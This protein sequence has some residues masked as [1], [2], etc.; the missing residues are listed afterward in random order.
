M[1]KVL[2][3]QGAKRIMDVC[4]KVKEEEKV[5]I[6][7]DYLK[8]DIAETLAIAANERGAEVAVMIMKARDMDGAEPPSHVAAAMKNADVIFTPLSRSITHS[9]AVKEAIESGTRGI[10]LSAFVQDQLISGGVYGD[11]EKIEPFC[12]KVAKLLEE[13][14]IAH[15]IN[16]A[17]TDI[18]M[19]L[20]NRVGNHH[21]GLAHNKGDFTTVPNI[22]ASI[23]P[24]EGSAEGTIVADASI[25]YYDIGVLETPVKY[26]VEKG[27]IIEITGGR[28]AKDI[29]KIM[30]DVNNDAVYNI[31]QLA[32]GLNPECKMRGVMLDDEGVLGTAHI[33]I[34]TST[35]LG[36]EIKAPGHYDAIMWEPT[37]YLDDKKVLDKGEW[38]V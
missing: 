7:T 36:G 29:A 2:M 9:N 12:I 22:E 24:V 26:M 11:F 27:K 1:Q 37:L 20:T 16:E 35:L 33:G 8:T 18:K 23:S 25:P 32:F 28:Q 14:K 31:A 38:L 17:G 15:L 30:A 19:D 6:V 34:G 4:A 13:A 5:L 21:T 3:I 10:M